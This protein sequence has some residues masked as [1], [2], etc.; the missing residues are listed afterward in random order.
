MPVNNW[1]K[2]PKRKLKNGTTQF[3][4]GRDFKLILKDEMGFI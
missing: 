4:E 3:F 1:W 2:C